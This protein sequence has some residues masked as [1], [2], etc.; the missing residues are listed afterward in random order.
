MFEVY[1]SQHIILLSP[2]RCP[3]NVFLF[4]RNSVIAS[5]SCQVSSPEPL[6]IS[7]S[8]FVCPVCHLASPLNGADGD[9]AAL[10]VGAMSFWWLL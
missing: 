10:H 3:C 2:R 6:G 7:W 4:N 9:Q 5:C 8:G 1:G